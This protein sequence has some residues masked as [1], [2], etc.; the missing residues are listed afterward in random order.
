MLCWFIGNVGQVLLC[1]KTD[2]N[3]NT[4]YNQALE[5]PRK[6]RRYHFV[7]SIENNKQS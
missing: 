3:I 6:H 7:I 1:E 2:E 4:W 5:Y